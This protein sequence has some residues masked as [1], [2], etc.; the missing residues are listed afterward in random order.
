MGCW[1]LIRVPFLTAFCEIAEDC[2][3]QI[4]E[5]LPTDEVV[6]KEGTLHTCEC[7]LEFGVFELRRKGDYGRSS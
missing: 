4:P 7:S 6:V 1:E 5:S 3:G 2:V